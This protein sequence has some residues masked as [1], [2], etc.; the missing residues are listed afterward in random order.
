MWNLAARG[1]PQLYLICVSIVA[2]RFLGPDD[3]GRQSFIGFTALSAVMLLTAGVPTAVIRYVGDA[4]GRGDPATARGLLHWAWRIEIAAALLAGAALA[5]VGLAGAQPRLAWVL[6][7]VAAAAGVLIRVPM[8]FLNGLQRW[9]EVSI[10]GLV[11]N[12]VGVVA[13]VLVLAFGGRITG[14]FAVEAAAAIVALFVLARIGR[15]RSHDLGPAVRVDAPIRRAALRYAGIASVTVVLTFIIWRRSEFF[16]LERYS[17]EAQLGFYSIAFAAATAPVVVFQGLTGVV[18]PAISTL[19]GARESDRIRT[20][21]AR[22]LRLLLLLALPTTAAALALGPAI[23]RLAYG[24]EFD[25][26]NK[27]LLILLLLIPLVPLINLSSALLAGVGRLGVNVAAGVAA[28]AIDV[29]LSVLLV[30]DHGAIGA[31]V[32]NDAAQ[33]TVGIPVIGYAWRVVGGADWRP[34]MVVRI[35]CSSALGGLAAWGCV[36]LL[37]DGY[38]LVAGLLLGSIGFVSGACLLRVL[39]YEDARWLDETMGRLLGGVLGRLIRSWAAPRPHAKA[40]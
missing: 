3:F 18:T 4:V 17:D 11:T 10:V 2:A 1:I 23:V 16:V 20:G 22:A 21:F 37:G 31:A 32:A 14:M 36:R 25:D 33:L 28:S 29:G 13:T 6:A 12:G 19:L 35:T 34:G 24:G 38:G 8:S 40:L 9:R 39:A 26:A 15:A 5:A 27:P 7:A 30:P